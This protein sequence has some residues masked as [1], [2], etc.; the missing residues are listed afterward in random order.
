MCSRPGPCNTRHKIYQKIARGLENISKGLD[1]DID[2]HQLWG[3]IRV[4]AYN[5]QVV[6]LSIDR[7]V[8]G[9]NNSLL[10]VDIERL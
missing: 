1:N 6:Y 9:L 5:W 7:A 4:I 2:F 3:T 10:P 8:I